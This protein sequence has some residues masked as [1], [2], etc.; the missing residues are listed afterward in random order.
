M[1]I[2]EREGKILIR[3]FKG[4]R[5]QAVVDALQL[6]MRDLFTAP[7]T[8]NGPPPR[9]ERRI[10]ATYDYCAPDGAL[11]YQNVRY[12]PKTF[13]VRRPSGNPADPWIWTLGDVRRVVYRLPELAEQRVVYLVEGEKDVDRL[14]SI[15]LPATTGAA[16]A[17][18]WR[19]E[20]A[21]QLAAAG[22][23]DVVILPDNDEPGMKYARAATDSLAKRKIRVTLVRLPGLPPV[24]PK[25]GADVSDWLDGGHTLEELAAVVHEALEAQDSKLPMPL[26]R[27]FSRPPIRPVWLVENLIRERTNGWIGAGA[28][29]GKS[30]SALDLLLACALGE[31][32]LGQFAVPRPLTIA[33]I[34]EEDDE[35]RIYDRSMKLCAGR[36][37]APPDNF[38]VSIRAGYRLDD[39]EALAPLIAWFQD[40]RPDLIV[41]DVFNRLHLKD[42]RK[43]DQI[44][45]VLWKLDQLRNEIG[46]ANLLAH[47]SRKQGP[48]GPDM[49]SGGQR[50]RGPSEFWGWAEN[51]LYLSPLKGKGHIIIEPE[52]K[53]AIVEPFK[54]HLEDTG[55]D[56]RRWVYDGVVQ[57]KVDRGNENRQRIVDVLQQQQQQTVE[58][59][60]DATGLALRTVK[61]HLRSLE[62]EGLADSVKEPGR[63]GRKLWLAKPDAVQVTDAVQP[64]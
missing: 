46:C 30:Y 13:R 40:I 5:A 21:D 36:G 42:E 28:K 63:G 14:W 44:M 15:G 26:S 58:Q 19:D 54:A 56:A 29:V 3:C 1:S 49:A 41:W 64:D 17:E 32:W 50:L 38:H 48:Q 47:H 22:V 55:P 8:S 61:A 62:T 37:I 57:G 27:L 53:D 23:R 20:Y 6:Q 16:G 24:Q 31:P 43:P 35:W 4:C 60:A 12:E 45:P 39:D 7:R 9:V 18:S 59:I 10:V 2:T 33:L 25:H 51:S 11:L 34:E 52:S